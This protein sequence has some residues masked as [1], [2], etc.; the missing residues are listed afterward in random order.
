MST[1]PAPAKTLIFLLRWWEDQNPSTPSPHRSPTASIEFNMLFP[2][3]SRLLAKH[4]IFPFPRARKW[5]RLFSESVPAT[6][7]SD[8]SPHYLRPPEDIES[9]FSCLIGP[10]KC[11]ISSILGT[12]PDPAPIS[13]PP[14]SIV[15]RV[16]CCFSILS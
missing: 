5:S 12:N 6:R 8:S 4:V 16:V 10:R 15:E 9:F 2:L 3:L 13:V 11:S 1:D 14:S 7:E